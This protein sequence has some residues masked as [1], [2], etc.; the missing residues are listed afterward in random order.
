MITLPQCPATS[1]KD[2]DNH[3]FG[4]SPEMAIQITR[5]RGSGIPL[6]LSAN[7]TPLALVEIDGDGHGRGMVVRLGRL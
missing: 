6:T 3:S 5:F 4:G 7:E 1:E 2:L